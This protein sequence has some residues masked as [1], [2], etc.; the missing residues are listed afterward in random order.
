M[1]ITGPKQPF[2]LSKVASITSQLPPAPQIFGRI[3]EALASGNTPI[4]D[5]GRLINQDIALAT[6][7]L[8]IANSALYGFRSPA[9]TVEEAIL[10]TGSRE[11]QR[12]VGLASASIVLQGDHNVY[13]TNAEFVWEH[14]VITAIAMEAIASRGV[15]D[16]A[17]AYT[18]GLLRTLGRIILA[19]HMKH[20]RSD[21]RFPGDGPSVPEWER[22]VFGV[23][24]GDVGAAACDGWRFPRKIGAAL[25]DHFEPT[26]NPAAGTLAHMLSLAC[27]ITTGLGRGLPG[28][29]ALFKDDPLRFRMTGITPDEVDDF[30]MLTMLAFDKAKT[31]LTFVRM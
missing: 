11:V 31:L 22:R 20:L 1:I 4:Q 9:S 7:T 29:E 19:R 16:P 2:D 6:Q 10:R 17:G 12:L 27:H 24:Y 3:T 14:S 26:G 13:G 28:E 30:T 5:I 21:E 18:I 8:R 25:R 15:E 23:T